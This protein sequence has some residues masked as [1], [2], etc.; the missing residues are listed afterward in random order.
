MRSNWQP[1]VTVVIPTLNAG[2]QL[3]EVL[4]AIADQQ[5]IVAEVLVIDSSSTDNT[6]AIA[7]SYSA[8]SW[9]RID[10]EEFG[11]GRTRQLGATLAT[12]EVVVFLT[13]DATPASPEW[14]ASLVAPLEDPEVAGVF[15]RQIPRPGAVPVIKYEIERVF[16]SPPPGFYSDTCSAAR[17]TTLLG[18]VPYRDVDFSEDFAFAADALAAGMRIHYAPDTAVRHS[19]DIRLRDYAGRMRAEIRGTRQAGHLVKRYSW[20]GAMARA[21]VSGLGDQRRIIADPEYGWGSTFKWLA[22]NPLY[23]FARWQGIWAGS[24]DRV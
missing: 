4:D 24:R 8:L 18:P 5:G 19:N 16:A 13:Q 21:L 12:S 7:R 2:E 11:H 9:H 15:A 1:S 22:L 14:L 20:P 6:E 23:H 17:R 3:A 10:R